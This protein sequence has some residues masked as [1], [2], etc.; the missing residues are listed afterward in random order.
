M[1]IATL[2]S[3]TF[4]LE[5]VRWPDQ[6]D[7]ARRLER[8]NGLAH[9]PISE[10]DDVLAG[11]AGDA[12]AE[13]L[14]RAHRAQAFDDA[15]LK[16]V[17]P[18]P[19]LAA[20]DPRNLRYLLLL[21]LAAGLLVAG[22]HVRERLW[23]AFDSGAGAASLDAWI[24]PPAYTGLPLLS[25]A[26]REGQAVAVPQGARIILRVHGALRRP[27]LLAGQNAVTPF[28]GDNSEYAGTLV[29]RESAPVRVRVAGHTVAR[30]TITAVADTPPNPPSAVVSPEAQAF[31]SILEGTPKMPPTARLDDKG[32]F[33]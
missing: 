16:P 3:L 10:R 14:W 12:L 19:S 31:E 32:L 20:R 7:A 24:D 5:H 1:P 25:L 11:G 2:L 26:G 6:N 4:A 18:R 33:K 27:A 8:D 21:V 23:G 30:W 15:G 28:S 22:G 13:A 29:V 17:L 9:R